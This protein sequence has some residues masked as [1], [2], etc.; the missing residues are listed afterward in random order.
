M[1]YIA[2]VKK[3]IL[4]FT[5]APGSSKSEMKE[6]QCTQCPKTYAR[7]SGL[8]RHVRAVHDEGTAYQCPHCPKTYKWKATLHNHV[9]IKHGEGKKIQCNICLKMFDTKQNLNRHILSHT[10]EKPFVCKICKRAFSKAWHLK[11][12]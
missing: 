9:K 10:G 12:H 8:K 2:K 6:Y 4:I 5:D 1:T 3:F 7:R 11:T